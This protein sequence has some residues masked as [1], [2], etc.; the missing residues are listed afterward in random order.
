MYKP[1]VP[2]LIIKTVC[3]DIKHKTKKRAFEH[4]KVIHYYETQK[5]FDLYIKYGQ[6]FNDALVM[7]GYKFSKGKY[8]KVRHVLYKN[9]KQ[10]VIVWE[11]V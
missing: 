10:K 3:S 7:R 9:K 8:R 5:G 4:R 2:Y 6:G 1:K 11:Q